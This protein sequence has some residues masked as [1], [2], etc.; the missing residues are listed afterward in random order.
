MVTKALTLDLVR[1]EKPEYAEQVRQQ[2][3]RIRK[4]KE[5]RDNKPGAP[6]GQKKLSTIMK[7]ALD[8][9]YETDPDLE[10][11]LYGLTYREVIILRILDRA[12]RHGDL[13]AFDRIIDRLE[14]KPVNKSEAQTTNMNYL[15]FLMEI[16]RKD[17]EEYGEELQKIGDLYDEETT[18]HE[19]VSDSPAVTERASVLQPP[20]SQN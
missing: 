13:Q 18:G 15:E 4:I 2:M 19:S 14:G 1:Y 20:R 7:H 8:I 11:E 10:P 16:G 17:R 3:L 5:L 6:T 12:A 9:V